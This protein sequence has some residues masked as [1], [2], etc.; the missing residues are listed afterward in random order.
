MKTD[1]PLYEIFHQHPEWIADLMNEPFPEPSTF[2]AP[3]HQAGRT[4]IGWTAHAV[5]PA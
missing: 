1:T 2:T 4:K 3:G 5:E